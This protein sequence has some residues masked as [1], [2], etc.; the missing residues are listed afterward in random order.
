MQFVR[1]SAV[2]VQLIINWFEFRT[3]TGYAV[4]TNRRITGYFR[5]TAQLQEFLQI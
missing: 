3:G 5:F 1:A 2:E 4:R